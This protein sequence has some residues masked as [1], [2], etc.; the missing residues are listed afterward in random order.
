VHLF[1]ILIAQHIHIHIHTPWYLQS[2]TDTIADV[3]FFWWNR[4]PLSME[5]SRRSRTHTCCQG[6]RRGAFTLLPFNSLQIAI[7]LNHNTNSLSLL[8]LTDF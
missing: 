2:I 5:A 1:L 7:L 6:Q 3:L 8:F 4:S